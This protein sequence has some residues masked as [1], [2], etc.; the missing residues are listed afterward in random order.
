M[1]HDVV[2]APGRDVLGLV[3]NFID[4]VDEYS[5]EDRADQW[6]LIGK[7]YLKPSGWR[8]ET[9]RG[10]REGPGLTIGRFYRC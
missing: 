3:F 2:V 9:Q 10:L 1:L 7:A 6:H 8:V 4:L 5:A